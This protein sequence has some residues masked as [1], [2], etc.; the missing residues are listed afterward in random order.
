M[1][2]TIYKRS[3]NQ[4][5]KLWKKRNEYFR[6]HNLSPMIM[7]GKMEKDSSS[8]QLSEKQ[9]HAFGMLYKI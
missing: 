1:T 9:D 6:S 7:Q 8:A 2:V 5:K 3:E 4:A